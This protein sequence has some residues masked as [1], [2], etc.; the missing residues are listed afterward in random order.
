MQSVDGMED[1]GRKPGSWRELFRVAWPL[2][3]SHGS[4]SLMLVVD[5]A[6]LTW[7][8]TDAL[9]ASLPAGLLFW[10]FLGV[11][12]GAAQYVNSFVA[13]YEGAGQRERV[14][15]SVW[16]GFYFSVL[17]GLIILL[18][19]PASSTFFA[20]MGHPGPVQRLESE[21]FSALCWGGG[22][23]VMTAALSAF[24]SGRGHTRVVMWVNVAAS[25]LNVVLDPLL[26][27]G[28]LGFPALGI[29]GAAYATAF[30]NLA[31]AMVFALM[32][33]RRQGACV[34]RVRTQWRF[35]P[36]L[37]QRLLRYGLPQGFH[38]F[39]DIVCFTVFVYLVG[40]LGKEQLAAT[41]LAFT[42]NSLAFVPLLGMGTAV[43]TLVGLRIG[44]GRPALA[45]RTT[46][47]AY[48]ICSGYILAFVV[49][50]LGF[51]HA[52]LE[53]FRTKM[54]EKEFLAM[55]DQVVVL[56][57][58]VSIYSLFD[59]MAVVF[60]SAIRGAGDTRFAMLYSLVTGVV[61]MIVPTYVAHRYFDGGL[62]SAWSAATAFIVVM[63]LGFCIRFQGGRWQ[64]MRVIEE[65]LAVPAPK[66]LAECE[67]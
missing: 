25:L 4:L 20:W 34:Y 52:I 16:Q 37:F 26:I 64:S 39:I 55:R 1:P 32:I 6:F 12:L 60:G 56:L 61:I 14:S 5:R 62:L 21:Y 49:I 40:V 67:A 27:F 54:N 22:P 51:P 24:Y 30:A 38:M 2:I 65:P 46:W 7:Y 53:P 15:A 35:D 63:G 45:A 50:Y 13:Q 33:L 36:E 9:A 19:I 59:A 17:A 66:T 23:L 47:L 10:T 11:P 43:A 28:K 44:E 42:L 3:I 48:L 31:A 8:S 58:F 57:R 29:R 41:N 18:G